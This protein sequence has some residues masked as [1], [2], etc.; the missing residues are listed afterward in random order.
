[1]FPDLPV[2]KGDVFDSASL[3]KAFPGFDAVYIN[4]SVDQ[5][6]R[7][8]ERQPEKEGIDNIIAAAKKTGIR[9]IIYLSSLIQRYQGMDGFNWWAFD[10]KQRAVNNIKA[11]GIAYS[12]FYPSSFMDTFVNLIKGNNLMIVSGSKQPMWFIAAPDYGK[13]VAMALSVASNSNQ[14]YVIQGAEPYTW[15]EA[16]DLVIKN[17][18]KANLKIRKTPLGV[19]KFLSVFS[20]RI[21]Y[22]AN[23]ITA[24][25]NY[26]EAFESSRTWGDLGKPQITL[27]EFASNL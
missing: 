10:I 22:V 5:Q 21:S 7:K 15:D 8:N 12:I 18:T 17:Y 20:P 11:S 6:S 24:L 27:A 16:A 25:N 1:V 9:R 4:L 19:L 23:I 3:E 14:E 2:V 13:Q 26:P